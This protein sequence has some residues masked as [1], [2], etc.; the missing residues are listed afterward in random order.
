MAFATTDSSLRVARDSSGHGRP[1][2]AAED[3]QVA[4]VHGVDDGRLDECAHQRTRDGG[5]S[6][7]VLERA[8][9]RG[10]MR[11]HY[12]EGYEATSPGWLRA[13]EALRSARDACARDGVRL[14]VAVHPILA[15][16]D[17][18][19]FAPIHARCSSSAPRR[20]SRPST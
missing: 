3:P 16:L 1:G 10:E 19:P 20:A 8:L 2:Q 4:P 11:R 9:T 13:R 12:L 18:E 15:D 17:E 6:L 5:E 14:A 7:T